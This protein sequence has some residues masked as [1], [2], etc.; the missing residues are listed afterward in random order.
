MKQ[1]LLSSFK[2]TLPLVAFMQLFDGLAACCNGMLRGIGR[3]AF[4]GWVNISCYYLIALPVSLWTTFEL[5]W[6]LMGLWGGVTLALAI[7]TCTELI[8]LVSANW[9]KSVD[10]ADWRNSRPFD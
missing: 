4:G 1:M 6:G 10:D 9:Q 3:P 8:F 5:H 7:V 2:R